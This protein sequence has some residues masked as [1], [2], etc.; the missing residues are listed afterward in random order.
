M[1]RRKGVQPDPRFLPAYLDRNGDRTT[2]YDKGRRDPKRYYYDTL[3]SEF[4]TERQYVKRSEGWTKEAKARARRQGYRTPADVSANRYDFSLGRHVWYESW[5]TAYQIAERQRGRI[6]TRGQ[7]KRSQDFNQGLE[8]IRAYEDMRRHLEHKRN[9]FTATNRADR[10]L[11]DYQYNLLTNPE[12][13]Y[14]QLLV[15]MGKRDPASNV[16]AGESPTRRGI[17]ANR[18]A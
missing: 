9:D 18:V 11:A 17:S 16:P 6:L 2:V 7:V 10:M 14:A 4:I 15:Y 3:T 12:G 1:A 13:E 8:A 5:V